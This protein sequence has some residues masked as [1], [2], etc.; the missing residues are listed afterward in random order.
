VGTVVPLAVP[1]VLALEGL[2]CQSYGTM[3]DVTDAAEEPRTPFREWPAAGRY[4]VYVAIGIVLA[5]VGTGLAGVVLVRRSLPDTEGTVHLRGLD[6]EVTVLRDGHGIPQVYADT[7]RDL[8][9]AQGYVQAQDRFW[10][11]DYRRHLTS[12]RL[13]ELLGP[14]A[15]EVDMAVRTM[16]WR[17]VA[18]Q[19]LPLLSA[20]TREYLQAFS[21]GVNDYLAR[22]GATRL[23]LEYLVLG[24]GGLDYQPEDWTPVDSLAWLKAMAWDLRGNMQDEIDRA[25]LQVTL[26]DSQIRELYPSY[27]AAAHD[28]IMQW[29][30]GPPRATQKRAAGVSGRTTGLGSSGGLGSNSWV[31]SGRYT[32][33][34]KPML[35]NDPHLAPSLPG[36]WYQMGLHCRTVDADCPFDV[37]GFTFAGLPGVVIGHNQRIAWGFTNLGPDVTDL[38]LEKLRGQEYLYDGRWLPLKEHDEIIRIHGQPSRTIT[39]R[40]TR[41]GPLLSDVSEELSTVGANADVPSGSPDRGNGYAVALKWTALQPSRTADAIFALDRASD[42][43]GFRA[44]A[45][46]FA[47]P[48]QNMVYADVAGNIGYQAPGRIP[49]RRGGR[50][51][52]FAVP[53]W[54]PANDW[55]GKFIPFA[56]L[57]SELN[58]REGFIVTANQ[59][60]VGSSYPHHLTSAWDAGYRSQRIRTL[61]EGELDHGKVDLGELTRMQLDTVNPMA[62]VLVPYLLEVLLP[63]QYYADGQRLLAG[64]DHRQGA[65]SGAAAYFNAVWRNLLRLTFHDQLKESVWPDGGDRWFAVVTRLL[66]D[67]DSGWWDDVTTDT[68]V[69]NRDQILGQA[70]RDA[71]DDLTRMVARDAPDW[72]WGGLHH[73]PLANETLGR[74]DIGLVRALFNRGPYPVGGSSAAVD[75]TAW[76]A[77]EGYDAVSVPS[78][79]MVV[80]L[81]DLDAS[82]WINLTGASGHAFDAHYTDQTELWLRGEYLPWAFSEEAVRQSAEHTLRLVPRS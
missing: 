41:H 58:P 56:E 64:W 13:S 63:S 75:A 55:T 38:Y 2:D 50:T 26:T 34:G 59:A 21:D 42:W 40:S 47:V 9:R 74:S 16:G 6:G 60:V 37:S 53:G 77:A 19:E 67:P 69:E 65:G 51:G 66:E 44:A 28:P 71:R 78:M 35:A 80:N 70:M 7:P 18:E 79:R 31:V 33:T 81:A 12:G 15:L 11:M 17:R 4:A 61:L 49:I 43:R 57:P 54:D 20:P 82:R 5:L 36:V 46:L 1:L 45:Q 76:D 3:C 32:T 27:D 68:V 8:F 25:R 14:D 10:Q 72:R 30:A 62:P 23:S 22:R 73:L 52:D 39:V 29:T 24:L 48:S